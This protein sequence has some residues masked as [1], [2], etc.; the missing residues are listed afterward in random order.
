MGNTISVIKTLAI[1]A[2]ISLILFLLSTHVIL[3]FYRRN[4]ARYAQ[5]LPLESISSGTT[6]L[7]DRVVRFWAAR[8]RAAHT[9]RPGGVFPD[10][11]ASQSDDDDGEEELATVDPAAMAVRGPRGAP[12]RPDNVRRLSRDLEEGFMDDSDSSDS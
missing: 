3:P 11:A 1:P 7:R 5:Y 6:S 10:S 9:G 2:V 4:Y 12:S 8:L